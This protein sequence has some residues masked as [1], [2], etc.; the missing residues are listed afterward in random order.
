MS[1]YLMKCPEK[2]GLIKPWVLLA[3][4][5]LTDVYCILL[6]NKRFLSHFSSLAEID[7]EGVLRA[8]KLTS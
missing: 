7:P 3:W 4:V 2:N 1:C 8:K 6:Q 5:L